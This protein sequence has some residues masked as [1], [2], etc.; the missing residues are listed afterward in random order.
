MGDP[1]SDGMTTSLTAQGVFPDPGGKNRADRFRDVL[2][3]LLHLI[4]ETLLDSSGCKRLLYQT[5]DLP[6]RATATG[7][8]LELRLGEAAPVAD[9][10]IPV[11]FGIDLARHFVDVGVAA[12]ERSPAGALARRLMRPG[13]FGPEIDDSVILEYDAASAV[14]EGVPVPGVFL[15]LRGEAGPHAVASSGRIVETLEDLAAWEPDFGER[16]AVER[17]FAAL[18]ERAHV[19]HVG[20]L[21][22]RT[23]R[24]IR[25]VIRNIAAPGIS[26][27]LARLGLTQPA[28]TLATVLSTMHDLCDSPWL[29]LDVTA[30]G[31]SPRIGLEFGP[32]GEGPDRKPGTWRRT[33]LWHWRPMIDRLDETGWCLSRKVG[34]LRD[35]PGREAV[36]E[37]Q[38]AFVVYRGINHIKVVVN[39]EAVHAKAYVGLSYIPVGN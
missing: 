14:P 9:I 21:P 22:G 24:A 5:G 33:G 37:E 17:A 26:G 7:F 32:R 3:A 35:W 13:G 36:F 1:Q 10:A 31:V 8:G 12:E 30:R 20:V 2:P 4:P 28:V 25:L 27:Y 19:H 29:S 18:P 23:P 39:G 38:G 34:G 11:A 6:G 15:R 16:R